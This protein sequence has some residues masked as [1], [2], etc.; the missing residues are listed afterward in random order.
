M[1]KITII[2]CILFLVGLLAINTCIDF[3]CQSGGEDYI[4]PTYYYQF[5]LDLNGNVTRNLDTLVYGG[6]N[7]YIEN[8]KLFTSDFSFIRSEPKSLWGQNIFLKTIYYDQN[9]STNWSQLS[10]AFSFRNVE[11]FDTKLPYSFCISYKDSLEKI[12][13]PFIDDTAS[14]W[15]NRG[16][17]KQLNLELNNQLSIIK[18]LKSG[19]VSSITYMDTI[20][21]DIKIKNNDEYYTLL[22]VLEFRKS[23]DS[24]SSHTKYAFVKKE[25]IL[26]T[27]SKN[28][29]LI[30]RVKKQIRTESGWF[31][32][33]MYVNDELIMIQ[34]SYY[35]DKYL[36][37]DK[38]FNELE[39]DLFN[40]TNDYPT[41][42]QKGT[43]MVF[44]NNSLIDEKRFFFVRN[45]SGERQNFSEL[46][47]RADSTVVYAIIYDNKLAAFISSDKRSINVYDLNLHRIRFSL[48]LNA[49]AFEAIYQ[50]TKRLKPIRFFP[51]IMMKDEEIQII[52]E[53]D[54]IY[55][56]S[57]GC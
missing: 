11:I 32:G 47:Q 20:I 57:D 28:G 13:N 16:K 30:E 27:I 9:Y 46:I 55:N 40:F 8:N 18:Q 48:D 19:F 33:K 38:N 50:N 29:S 39:G 10:S 49:A 24:L 12:T 2:Y 41:F 51:L 15:V 35:D 25:L 21:A 36:L 17:I 52:I 23:I 37:L 34:N 3:P 31:I 42:P 7:R 1:N 53:Y 56:Y 6:V 14:V 26:S 54:E 44:S 43:R 45:E 5:V 4:P 22:T